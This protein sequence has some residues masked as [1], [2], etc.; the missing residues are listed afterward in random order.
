MSHFS[1]IVIG[2][3]LEE[4]LEP[5]AEQDF[6]ES[7]GKFED[8]EQEYLD[9][10]NNDETDIVVLADGTLKTKYAQEFRHFNPKDMSQGY[11]FPEG[12]HIRAGKYQELFPTFEEFM[13]GWVGNS[14]RDPK[15]GKYGFWF[16]PNAKWDWYSIG[17]RWSGFFKPKSGASGQLGKPGTFNNQPEEG[18]VDSLKLQ[19]IDIEAM[20]N[21][22]MVEAN[23]TYDKIEELLKGR[24][25]PSWNAIRDKH[26]DDIQAARVE[27][28][29]NEV[30]SDFLEAN[31]DIWGDF[32]ETFGHSRDEYVEKCKNRTMVPFAVVKDGKWYEKGEMGWF[33]CSSNEMSQDDWNKQFW[34]M[35]NS[36]D[37]DTQI[38]IVDCHI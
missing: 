1:V 24:T 22:K 34:D 32:Y 38:T 3:D 17:G 28:H 36:L 29:N 7:L 4:Q 21:H 15:T 10:Y 27:F 11:V 8:I 31:F 23:K 33:G 19:D 37:P 12:S 2:N 14:K 30:V 35:I 6:N 20:I 16:N 5:Y 18:Y 26:G 9:K 25:F 13:E